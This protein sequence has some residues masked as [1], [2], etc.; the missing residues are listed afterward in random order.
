MLV[1]KGYGAISLSKQLNEIDSESGKAYVSNLFY[2]T[3]EKNVQF[4][5]VLSKL[6]QKKP[7][8]SVGI[9]IKMGYICFGTEILPL[10][11]LRTKR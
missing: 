3:L 2:G 1:E 11:P 4:D 6:T 7:K 10:M 9:A 8:P 5:Y